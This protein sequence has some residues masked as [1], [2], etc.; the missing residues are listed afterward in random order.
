MPWSPSIGKNGVFIIIGIILSLSLLIYWYYKSVEGFSDSSE[1]P[2]N[3]K[4]INYE[5]SGSRRYNNYADLVDIEKVPIIP[6]GPNGD[7]TLNNLLITPTVEGTKNSDSMMGISYSNEL[8]YKTP[9]EV[10][11]TLGRIL[12]CE[13]VKTWDCEAFEDPTFAANCAVLGTASVTATSGVTPYAIVWSNGQT[14]A[15]ASNLSAGN[16]SLTITDANGCSGTNSVA[17]VNNGTAI[18]STVNSP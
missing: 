12:M 6:N 5:E 16:Y 4:R 1:Y 2:V 17:I 14:G 10:G 7:K 11:S 18:N 13:S 15:N 3:L 9:P 8:P